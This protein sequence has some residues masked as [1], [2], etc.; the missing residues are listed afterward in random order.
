MVSI[1]DG[2]V[3]I[4]FEH[5]LRGE[6]LR[7]MVSDGLPLVGVH[8]IEDF[9]TIAADMMRY[10]TAKWIG[11]VHPALGHGHKRELL[12]LWSV[13]SSGVEDAWGTPSTPVKRVWRRGGT[14]NGG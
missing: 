2:K 13:V 10:L 6:F 4:R 3:I 11:L 5:Q 8:T 12:P 1:P 9:W 7:N 14:S